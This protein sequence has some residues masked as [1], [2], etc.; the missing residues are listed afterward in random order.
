MSPDCPS[1]SPPRARATPQRAY[2]DF[3][4][5]SPLAERFF[6]VLRDRDPERPVAPKTA[7]VALDDI[8]PLAPAR[9]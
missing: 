2:A 8:A 6:R 7:F 1:R 9:N 5:S 3:E 4:R